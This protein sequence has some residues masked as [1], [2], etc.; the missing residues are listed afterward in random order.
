MVRRRPA[1][2][3]RI[4]A[5][6]GVLI[7][8]MV[9]VAVASLLAAPSI[10]SPVLA[11]DGGN[12]IARKRVALPQEPGLLLSHAAGAAQGPQAH[13]QHERVVVLDIAAEGEI[14][15]VVEAQ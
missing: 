12:I 11:Y 8:C 4:R 3:W 2:A 15:D 6:I 14:A 10:P 5:L 7:A 13:R 9:A 1:A